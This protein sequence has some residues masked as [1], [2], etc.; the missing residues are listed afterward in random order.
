MLIKNGQF[1]AY[2]SPSYVVGMCNINPGTEY[3]VLW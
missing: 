1:K 2:Y 3:G